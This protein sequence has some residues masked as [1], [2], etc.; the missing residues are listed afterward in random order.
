MQITTRNWQLHD[1]LNYNFSLITFRRWVFY[2]TA[3]KLRTHKSRGE[4]S[5]LFIK[6]VGSKCFKITIMNLLLNTTFH[7]LQHLKYITAE[8][9]FNLRNFHQILCAGYFVV[10]KI[11]WY[12]AMNLQGKQTGRERERGRENKDVKNA[13]YNLV[14]LNYFRVVIT[15]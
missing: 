8:R 7:W 11:S 2:A 9:H 13:G 14:I 12:F 1:Y 10:I 3:I 5:C 6:C 15:T 4:D